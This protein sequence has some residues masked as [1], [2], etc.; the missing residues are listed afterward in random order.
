[1]SRVKNEQTQAHHAGDCRNAAEV[2]VGCR[3]EEAQCNRNNHADED[4][5]EPEDPGP[6]SGCK[7][8]ECDF[9]HF[10]AGDQRDCDHE[11]AHRFDQ[12]DR[13]LSYMQDTH[14]GVF[15]LCTE[16]NRKETNGGAARGKA[17]SDEQGR[18]NCRVDERETNQRG[19]QEAGISADH[20]G[21]DH[22]DPVQHNPEVSEEVSKR[23]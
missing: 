5:A 21:Q 3:A 7:G 19:D 20:D 11:D 13:V 14:G 1:M 6:N 23:L 17:R 4:G 12:D 22:N 9:C 8:A 16:A 10:R 18:E 2:K 15:T